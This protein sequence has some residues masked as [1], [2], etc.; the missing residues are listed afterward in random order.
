[1][2]G[3]AEFMTNVLNNAKELKIVGV[4]LPKAGSRTYSYLKPGILFPYKLYEESVN[5][6]KD[7]AVVQDQL[8][9]PDIDVLSGVSFK[10]LENAK[11]V[12]D[13][14]GQRRLVR[15]N[16]ELLLSSIKINPEALDFKNPKDKSKEMEIT[17]EELVE[18][19][20]DTLMDPEFQEFIYD[21]TKEGYF[22][23]ATLQACISATEKYLEYVSAG[24][25]D[26]PRE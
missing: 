7:S 13:R 10:Y 3:D 25:T 14:L 9:H 23:E 8:K 12:A 18:M 24:G 2:S 16:L 20:I 17:E 5:Q 26:S 11:G 15:F 19:M 1:M 6:T 22:D 4:V 21:I